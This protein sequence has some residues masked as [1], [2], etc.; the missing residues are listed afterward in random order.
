[1]K[2]LAGAV[3]LFVL[4]VPFLPYMLIVLTVALGTI[5]FILLF[6]YAIYLLTED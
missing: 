5:L 4:L 2:K 1:M 6:F 3:I